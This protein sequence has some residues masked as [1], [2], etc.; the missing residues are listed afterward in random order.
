[1]A[2]GT[3]PETCG[4]LAH[5]DA[6]CASSH[7][8]VRHKK[9]LSALASQLGT[10][11]RACKKILQIQN[12][13]GNGA[14]S[15]KASVSKTQNKERMTGEKGKGAGGLSPCSSFNPLF[16]RT[17]RSAGEKLAQ[18]EPFASSAHAQLLHA[19]L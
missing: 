2:E 12:C 11:K 4:P 15:K 9:A 17:H 16:C 6:P 19:D 1:M 8:P 13:P 10:S 5:V 7:R 18:V 3:D 14:A